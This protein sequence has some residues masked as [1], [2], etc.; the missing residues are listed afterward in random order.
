MLLMYF[1]LFLWY[2]VGWILSYV[3]YLLYTLSVLD[4][5]ITQVCI[6]IYFLI[7]FLIYLRFGTLRR[8]HNE[9]KV[10]YYRHAC[11]TVYSK[12]LNFYCIIIVHIRCFFVVLISASLLMQLTSVKTL[13]ETNFE[14]KNLWTCI[15]QLPIW[16]LI[17][18]KKSL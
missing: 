1:I 3:N 13:N 15:W 9:W 5:F 11:L 4:I 8:D 18:E 17:W 16:T 7:M 12:K 10:M 6:V 2:N 14:G